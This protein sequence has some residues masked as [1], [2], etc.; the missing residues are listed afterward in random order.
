[1][2]NLESEDS[3]MMGQ[4]SGLQDDDLDEDETSHGESLHLEDGSIAN[5][6]ELLPGPVKA[7]AIP[8]ESTV[9]GTCS[10]RDYR[11]AKQFEHHQPRMGCPLSSAG[12]SANIGSR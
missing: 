5:E 7:G 8:T 4:S 10:Q 3:H 6:G 9:S 12:R 1:M 11:R 2:A